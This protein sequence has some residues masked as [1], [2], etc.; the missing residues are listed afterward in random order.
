MTDKPD[1]YEGQKILVEVDTVFDGGLVVSY[2]CF[3][4]ALLSPPIQ[5]CLYVLSSLRVINFPL[6]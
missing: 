4:G 3:R 2:G 6:L 1:L 5:L